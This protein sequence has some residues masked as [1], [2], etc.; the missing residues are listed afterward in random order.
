[1]FSRELN[2][3]IQA[4][5]EDGVLEEYEKNALI[6]RATAEGVDLTEL[7]IYVNSLLQKRQRELNIQKT[8]TRTA[9]EQ[10]KKEA[11]GKTCPQCGRQ[12]ESMTIRCECGYEFRFAKAVSS[13][14]NLYEELNNIQFSD[15]EI[16][17]CSEEMTE[18]LGEKKGRR[19]VKDANGNVVTKINKV[20]LERLRKQKQHDLIA[21]F[22]VPNTKEDVI[23]FLA[24][25]APK[26]KLKGGI[27][28]TMKGQLTIVIPVAI[29]TFLLVTAIA[30]FITFDIENGAATGCFAAMVLVAVCLIYGSSIINENKEKLVWKEKFNQVLMKGRSL[31]ADADFAR[32][33]DYYE[34][35]MNKN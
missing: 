35:K 16:Q 9:L 13:V 2:D 25:A 5:L 3:L 19:I 10:Q 23:E 20:K 26:S 4:T 14:Q 7:E 22:P 24:L 8:A 33:L 17:S 11:L 21:T 27:F 31:R 1:M 6:K 30:T 12:V 18:D 29:I 15:T 34:Q 32:M 28:A